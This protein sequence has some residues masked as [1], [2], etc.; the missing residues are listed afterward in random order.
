MIRGKDCL[1]RL[2]MWDG[3]VIATLVSSIVSNSMITAM[4]VCMNVY[5]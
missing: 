3:D 1:S 2:W 4:R 5:R